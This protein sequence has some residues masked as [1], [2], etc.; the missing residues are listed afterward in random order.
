MKIPISDKVPHALELLKEENEYYR[1]ELRPLKNPPMWQILPVELF[2][3]LG[4]ATF[5]V[6]LILW[7]AGAGTIA[8]YLILS[9]P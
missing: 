6:S 9:R 1:Q 2:R 8:A 7:G 4:L 5:V 3:V